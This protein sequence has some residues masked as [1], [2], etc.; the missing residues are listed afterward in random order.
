M[1]TGTKGVPRADREEQIQR[2]AIDDFSE[3]GYAG[4]SMVSIAARAGI[5]KPLIYQYFGSKDGLY[6]ACLRHVAEG[7]LAR[8]TAARTHEVA[9]DESVGSRI[10][11]LGRIFAALEPQRLAWRL[12]YDTTA[13]ATGEIGEAAR[14]YQARTTQ[15]AFSGSER[16]LAARGVYSTA[17]ASA[18]TA[19]WIGLVNSLIG[20]WTDH[21]DESAAQMT[22]RCY[23]L[24]N[25][26]AQG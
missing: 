2:V 7:M 9:T 19:L 24:L 21:P 4:A 11:T 17:D 1:T 22:Q 23:R 13:P 8:I 3:N 14:D 15:W 6:L 18:L 25:A 16:F 10:E 5:S 26:V 12:M 20:W